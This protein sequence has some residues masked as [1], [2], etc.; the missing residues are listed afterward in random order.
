MNAKFQ[1]DLDSV[2]SINFLE[3]MYKIC[4]NNSSQLENK[5]K[6]FDQNENSERK[7]LEITTIIN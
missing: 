6:T 1:Y 7:I 4:S 3:K 5:K 2:L